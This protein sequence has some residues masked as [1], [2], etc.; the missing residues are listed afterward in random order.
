M[1][2]SKQNEIPSSARVWES[3]VLNADVDAVWKAVRD[4]KFGFAKDVKSV[5]VNGDLSAVGGT[6]VITYADNTKQTIQIME[7][8]DLNR[9]ISYT[10]IASEPAYVFLVHV[11]NAA[12]RTLLL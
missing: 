2:E 3:T 11:L 10:V 7:I 12:F 4:G 8:S 5:E 1:A 9:S 6:R